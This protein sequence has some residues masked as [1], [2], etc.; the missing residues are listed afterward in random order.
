MRGWLYQQQ[1]MLWLWL[2]TV[3][4]MQRTSLLRG[5][6][7]RIL[8]NYNNNNNHHHQR[9]MP[10]AYGVFLSQNLT[11]KQQKRLE[12][13]LLGLCREYPYKRT[14]VNATARSR[15]DSWT[16]CQTNL[17]SASFLSC[18]HGTARICCRA[19]A[20]SYRSISPARGRSAANPAACRCCCRSTGQTDGRSTVS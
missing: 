15:Y 4:K 9:H 8:L 11:T 6:R 16:S 3:Y 1:L 13:L 2:H 5:E 17:C 14:S 10:L 19:P 20:N 12:K 18:Q 7:F